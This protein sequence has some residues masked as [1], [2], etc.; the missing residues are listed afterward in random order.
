MPLHETHDSSAPIGSIASFPST[1]R[2][3][4]SRLAGFD[5]NV[6]PKISIACDTAPH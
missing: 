5:L 2:T 1:L 3:E 6:E 4:D